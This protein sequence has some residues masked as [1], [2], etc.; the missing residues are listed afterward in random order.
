MEDLKIKPT[1]KSLNVEMA[2]GKLTF[3][4]CSIIN[5]PKTFFN[6]ILRWVE[7]YSKNPPKETLV[8]VKFEYIDSASVKS[9]FEILKEL[10]HATRFKKL[11]VN[12]HYDLDDPEILELGEIIQNKL[13]VEFNFLEYNDEE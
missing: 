8:D 10:S 9:F 2:E 4:G 11:S 7:D 6:P 13:N 12:W 1:G 3:S 5:D